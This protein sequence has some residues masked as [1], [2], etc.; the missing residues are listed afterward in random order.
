MEIRDDF[1]AVESFLSRLVQYAR[2]FR[3]NNL[4]HWSHLK[5][6]EDF[7]RVYLMQNEFRFPFEGIYGDGRDLA[8]AMADR[9]V[10]FND[11]N[12]FPTLTSFV[13]SFNGGWLFQ[14]NE[15]ES[16]SNAAKVL[17]ARVS[18]PPWA[19]ERMIE[20]FDEQ[21]GLLRA[22]KQTI[23]SLRETDI[24]KWEN[25][26]KSSILPDYE[27]ILTAIHAAGKMFERLPA[28]YSGKGE[29]ALR[30]NMLVI[31][32]PFIDGTVTGETVNKAG[33]TDILVR[34]A[35][36]NQFIGE[37]KFWRGKAVFLQTITQLLSY[38]SWRDTNAGIIIFVKN[39]DFTSVLEKIPEYIVE[40][41]NFARFVNKIDDGFIMYQMN[42]NGDTQRL[43][44]VAVMVYHIP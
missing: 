43:I 37:C 18:N 16:Q 38:L 7:S 4:E 26:I 29:E 2:G 5:N 34:N 17:L 1:K 28:T 23:D 44:D 21:I 6:Q 12:L 19:V 24:Y 39:D 42:I 36:V 41:P 40:H 31:L 22:A 13:Q 3:T 30:D 27:R 15:L 14:I 25:G 20:L 35:N 32:Q 33:K 11:V 10:R 9:L 8:V